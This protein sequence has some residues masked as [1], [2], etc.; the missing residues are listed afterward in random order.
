M[1]FVGVLA[2]RLLLLNLLV[3]VL[4]GFGFQW[5]FALLTLLGH[6]TSE[7][8][9]A[10]YPINPSLA[11]LPIYRRHGHVITCRLH[12]T[13]AVSTLQVLLALHVRR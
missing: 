12:G 5:L 7:S 4:C 9:E 2:Q 3:F 1:V 13:L 8:L 10:V 11:L 6:T